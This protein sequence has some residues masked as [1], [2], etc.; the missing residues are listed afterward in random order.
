[1]QFQKLVLILCCI[2]NEILASETKAPASALW[3]FIVLIFFCE[4]EYD[5]F[6]IKFQGRER[7]YKTEASIFYENFIFA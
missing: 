5:K 3:D 6:H 7:T 2:F 4:C 1:M